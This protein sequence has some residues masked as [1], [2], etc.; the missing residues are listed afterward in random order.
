VS[1][2]NDSIIIAFAE[3]VIPSTNIKANNFFITISFL[4]H[5]SPH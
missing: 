4:N 3:V 1:P 2:S 5:F